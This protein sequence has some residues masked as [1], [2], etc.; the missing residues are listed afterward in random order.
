MSMFCK[1]KHFCII[2]FCTDVFFLFKKNDICQTVVITCDFFDI[3]L[4]LYICGRNS[5]LSELVL[6]Y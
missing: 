5:L 4:Y 1:R 2:Y 6:V 3:H